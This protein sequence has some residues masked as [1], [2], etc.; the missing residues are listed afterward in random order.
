[1][2]SL[3]ILV[4][5]G[6][7]SHAGHVVVLTER[8]DLPAALQKASSEAQLEV[9]AEP[10][11]EPP[12]DLAFDRA[13]A[14]Q[15]VAIADHA[16]AAV[17]I[18][19]AEVW[20]V[21]ADGRVV[22]HAPLA[23][24]SSARVFGAIAAHLLDEL[25]PFREPAPVAAEPPP[26]VTLAPLGVAAI[27]P[28]LVGPERR[29]AP[30]FELA[31]A[32]LVGQRGMT[33]QQNPPDTPAT[34]PLYQGNTLDVV[35]VKASAFPA[36][37]DTYGE[38]LT[39]FGATL[40][41]Q[42]SVGATLDAYDVMNDTYGSYA[43]AYTAVELAAHYRHKS[44][45]VLF[46]GMVAY[47]AASWS[48]GSDLPADVAI[49]STTYQHIDAGG[50]VEL[51]IGNRAR[52]GIGARYMHML[53]TGDVSEQAWYGSGSSA[54]VGADV[55]LKLPISSAVYLRGLFQYRRVSMGFDGTGN[56]SSGLAVSNI[57]DAWLLGGVEL[58]IAI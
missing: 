7:V 24:V 47:T 57:T 31:A 2:R 19:N 32:G 41:I 29:R 49:P 30:T 16:D 3:L 6:T 13:A 12:G 58:G 36:P 37:E 25:A 8:T 28:T 9:V 39:G 35:A 1:M 4:A 48:L 54:G 43:L 18:D 45:R 14:A 42:R 26:A 15:H 50:T 52:L 27:A 56:V 55:D 23:D 11:E 5:M 10:I 17:W 40:E 22:R 33:F 34:A 21:T 44:G 38:D 53:T 51:A 46:D 20:V